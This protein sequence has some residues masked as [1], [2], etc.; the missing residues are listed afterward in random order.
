MNKL[1]KKWHLKNKMPKNPNLEQR[2]KWHKEHAKHCAC[3]PSQPMLLRLKA[4]A[5]K[6]KEQKSNK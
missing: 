6:M 4:E 1:N 5:K 2:I 3:R